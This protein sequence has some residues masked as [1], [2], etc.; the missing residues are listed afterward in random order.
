MPVIFNRAQIEE[1]LLQV[2]VTRAIEEGFVAYSQG[3]VVV[4]P[5]GELVFEDPPG[6]VHI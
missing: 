2:D 4:P 1:A 5:V 3:K 6:D